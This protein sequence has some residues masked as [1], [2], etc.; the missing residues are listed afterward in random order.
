MRYLHDSNIQSDNVQGVL[1]VR[2][3]CFINN[4]ADLKKKNLLIE[5][6][7]NLSFHKLLMS[8]AKF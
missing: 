7:F 6:T 8:T 3:G 2:L 4:S 1:E 5:T